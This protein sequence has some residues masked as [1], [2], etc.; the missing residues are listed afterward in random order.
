MEK[1][2]FRVLYRQFLFRMVD[3]ELLSSHAQGDSNRL[4]GQFASL[5]IF[6]SIIMSLGA[7][8]GPR[9]PA[10]KLLFG[11]SMEHLMIATGM[12]IVGLFAV[13]SWD[14]TFPNRGDVLVLAPLP[15][16]T[17]TLFLAKIAAV[18]TAMTLVVAS[19]QAVAGI[20]WPMNLATQD[21]PDFQ[22]PA[23]NY[24]TA[25]PPATAAGLE[26]LLRRDLAPSIQGELGVVIGVLKHNERHIYAYGTAKPDSIYLIG[27]VSKTFT[28][29]L[30]AQ[31]VSDSSVRLDQPLRELMPAGAVGKP[32]GLE[33]TLLDLATHRS[34]LPPVQNNFNPQ[35]MVNPGA[36]PRSALWTVVS[37][38]GVEHE[39][40]P[41]FIY[42]NLGYAALGEALAQRAGT[43]YSELLADNITKPLGMPDTATD[44][45]PE[46]EQRL[47]PSYTS[48]H[49]P[50]LVW[51]LDA[52]NGAGGLRSTASDL[53]T[54][55]DANLRAATPALRLQRKLRSPIVP[56]DLDIALGWLHRADTGT[57]FHNGIMT[58]YTSHALF[59]PVE[60]YAVIV[61]TNQSPTLVMPA[62][63]IASHVQQR[64]N[65][66][67]AI[68]F[69]TI[70][71]PGTGGFFSLVRMYLVY[72]FVMLAAG[73]FIFCCVLGL[74]GVAAQ[75]LPRR[76]FL[77]VSSLL[78]LAAFCI[79]VF[80][81]FAQP[82][83]VTGQDLIEV[84][85]SGLLSW[86]PSFW[87]LGL[88]QQ[89]IG[90]PAMDALAHRAW[91][92]LAVAVSVT[93]TAYALSCLRTLRQIVEEPDILPGA[94]HIG[95]L[96]RIGA[97]EQFTVRTLMRSRQHRIMLAFYLGIGFALTILLVKA[98]A[99]QNQLADAPTADAW[100]QVNTPLLSAS[101]VMLCFAII[102]TRIVF[103]L[104]KD[105]RANWVFRITGAG[106]RLLAPLQGAQRRALFFL[107]SAPV[108]LITAVL[109]FRQW[110]IQAAL[111]H[112][113][114]LL[115]LASV[116]TDICL[117]SL[118][119]IPF[120]CSYLPGKSRI[121]MAFLA[122]ALLL[123]AITTSVRY[124]LQALHDLK[125][126]TPMLLGFLIAAIAARLLAVSNARSAELR[127]EEEETP[128][129][130]ILGIR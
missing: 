95:W 45:T 113:G 20:A 5:L 8:G 59:N 84:N 31:M 75:L 25:E 111:G 38:L 124:E 116:L 85:G 51:Y 26:S 56:G 33:I 67:P 103:S 1:L 96:P 105:V 50:Q 121:N 93:G 36:F 91:V 97:I 80:V 37:R 3:L 17:R 81:Y 54:Y 122:G 100:G 74:Q 119:K 48:D 78:Q 120:T 107:S 15:V 2:Q 114:V 4:L 117:Y 43:T 34:G 21:R 39:F 47:I 98:P 104:P 83:F 79:L 61:L 106:D 16:R 87:F 123:W 89:G 90:S 86:S 130:Q 24:L 108:I 49:Q 69:R 73:G 53:L 99:T 52:F 94:R 128:A 23:L 112:L 71:V 88:F 7:L 30:L 68:S 58:G 129:V 6:A 57:Y 65:G 76:V 92:G 14:S 115:L 9:Q 35:S 72:W 13:L 118:L 22:M 126:M 28:A 60:D 44:L 101:I 64:L 62:D 70:T 63:V 10:A 46:Q 27:S 40:N 109:A 55:L 18:A 125:S 12:L 77:R 110:P 29:L 82:I 42:S 11:W 19:F 32:A 127:F 66:K 41:P 102:G